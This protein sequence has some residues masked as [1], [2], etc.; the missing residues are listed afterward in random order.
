MSSAWQPIARTRRSG[1]A[2]RA[3]SARAS[4]GRSTASRRPGSAA[5]APR[6]TRAALSRR[7]RSLIVSIGAEE[8]RRTGTRPARRSAISRANVSSTSSSPGSIRSRIS[9]RK[10][11][12]PPLIRTSSGSCP[13]RRA[14]LPSASVVTDVRVELRPHGEE[15]ARSC[16]S[17][18]SASIISRQ[19]RVGEAVA[20]GREERRRRRRGTARPPS[21]ARRSSR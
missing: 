2:A 7:C 19:R 11:K 14:T 20:V 18:G 12:K 5:T 16:R 17:R 1:S 9:R 15:H 4:D 8:A 6:P 21:A 3:G 13:R 10:T